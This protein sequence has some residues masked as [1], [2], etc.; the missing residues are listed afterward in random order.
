MPDT[1]LPGPVL[2][3]L[4]GFALWQSSDDVKRD[5]ELVCLTCGEHLCDA[6]HLDT[7]EVLANCAAG[8]EHHWQVLEFV[9]YSPADLWHTIDIGTWDPATRIVADSDGAQLGEAKTA[10]EARMVFADVCD[11]TVYWEPFETEGEVPCG[12]DEH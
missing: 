3:L 6:E 12:N 9:S 7:L 2:T 5:L 4:R 11:G 1:E 10:D 8:H